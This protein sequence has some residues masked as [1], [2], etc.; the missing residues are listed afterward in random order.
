MVNALSLT[1]YRG[2]GC[3]WNP[4]VADGRSSSYPVPVPMNKNSDVFEANKNDP[5]QVSLSKTAPLL[6]VGAISQRQWEKICIANRKNE[7]RSNRRSRSSGDLQRA[8]FTGWSK[9]IEFGSIVI[10]IFNTKHIFFC[11]YA[12]CQKKVFDWWPINRSRVNCDTV[13]GTI[14]ITNH[15][16]ASGCKPAWPYV[17]LGYVNI[18][19]ASSSCDGNGS[20]LLMY[21]LHFCKTF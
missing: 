14:I 4:I 19:Q 12:M 10:N 5:R 20:F 16:A 6:L 13:Y 3:T 8:I 11:Q 17:M 1:R 9:S 18:Q 2:R 15:W 21:Y 7:N